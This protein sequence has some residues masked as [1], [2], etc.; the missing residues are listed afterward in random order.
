MRVLLLSVLLIVSTLTAK[1]DVNKQIKKTNKE[2]KSFDRKYSSLHKK[3]SGTAKAIKKS[4]KSLKSQEKSISE[5]SKKLEQSKEKYKANS[6]EL[7]EL[8][9]KQLLL[10][11]KQGLIEKELIKSI[12]R[13]ISINTL[14]RDKYTLTKESIIT[15]EILNEL[16]KQTQRKIEKL[17]QEHNSNVK[18]ISNTYR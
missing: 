12:A 18:T 16:N 7:L 6:T 8:K 13:N 2:I 17:E 9:D 14:S 1:Q 5:L 11:G 4:E 10:E 3:I 15:E